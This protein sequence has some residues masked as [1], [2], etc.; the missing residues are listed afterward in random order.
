M[1][2]FRVLWTSAELP[3]T[4]PRLTDQAARVTVTG[5]VAEMRSPPSQ[6][7]TAFV[8]G[9]PTSLRSEITV[10]AA[11]ETGSLVKPGQM[12]LTSLPSPQI[13]VLAL[14]GLLMLLS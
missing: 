4:G 7:T 5:R 13:W 11:I 2:W 9:I 14:V 12:P 8:R 1:P 3:I 10:P 6:S